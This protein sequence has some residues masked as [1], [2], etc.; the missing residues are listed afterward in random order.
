[1]PDS[2][3][4]ALEAANLITAFEQRPPYQRNDYLHWIERARHP[5]TRRKRINQMIDELTKGG[6]YMGMQ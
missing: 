5:E 4:A 3:R 1:M 2:L 6:I